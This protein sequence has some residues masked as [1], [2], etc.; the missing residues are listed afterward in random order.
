M[1][2]C[3]HAERGEVFSDIN[4]SSVIV[5]AS[6]QPVFSCFES[7]TKTGEALF[8]L[9]GTCDARADH[10]TYFDF[11]GSSVREQDWCYRKRGMQ[12]T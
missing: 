5:N 8:K 12:A 9:A 2:S 6:Y 1:F 11:C 3:F 4:S 7:V 10:A